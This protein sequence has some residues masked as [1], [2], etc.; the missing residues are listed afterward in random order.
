MTLY[1]IA[2]IGGY[3]DFFQFFPIQTFFS[4]LSTQVPRTRI[5]VNVYCPYVVA[6]HPEKSWTDLHS[7]Q[8]IG[9]LVPPFLYPSEFLN[10]FKSFQY[11]KWKYI[12]SIHITLITSENFFIYLFAIC[13]FFHDISNPSF[14]TLSSLSLSFS[15][16]VGAGVVRKEYIKI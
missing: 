15:L 16:W 10:S 13:N 12:I 14:L 11:V 2:P 4:T 9:V 8:C 1:F 7:P 3:V 5:V 6:K